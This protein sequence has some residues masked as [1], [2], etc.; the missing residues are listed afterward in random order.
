MKYLKVF[1]FFI[2][3]LAFLSLHTFLVK[4]HTLS[5]EKEGVYASFI[6]SLTYIPDLFF[7]VINSNE[8]SGIPAYYVPV[9]STFKPFNNLSE[10]IYGSYGI[11][12][13][14]ADEWEVHLHNFKTEKTL[15]KWE[16]KEVNYDN[17]K[18]PRFYA[19]SEIANPIILADSS[20]LAG[21][22][23]S[24][25]FFKLDKYSNVVWRNND[26][27]IHHSANLDSSGNVWICGRKKE[28]QAYHSASKK[29]TGSYIDDLIVL[30]DAK[31]GIPL[32]EKSLIEVISNLKKNF[33]SSQKCFICKD[34]F[35]RR[36]WREIRILHSTSSPGQLEA[37]D[38]QSYSPDWRWPHA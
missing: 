8:I 24:Y 25:N 38:P 18:S 14:E 32:F 17:R 37:Q 22:I 26:Y 1:S 30:L 2:V 35:D 15:Y 31:T 12:N 23:G 4:N 3:I 16:F 19:N 11:F 20:L 21:H 36:S 5:S 9:D 29:Y 33:K 27:F 13:K 6:K 34:L 7:K 28:A 10:D